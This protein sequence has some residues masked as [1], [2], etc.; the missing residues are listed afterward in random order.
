MA[1]QRCRCFNSSVGILVVRTQSACPGS[2]SSNPVSIPR[3]EFWSFGLSQQ[4]RH[5]NKRVCFN[6]SVGILVVRTLNI[7]SSRHECRSFNSSVG[8]LVVRT[9]E[10]GQQKHCNG[11]FNSSV[12]ILVVRTVGSTEPPAPYQKVSIPRSEFWSFGHALLHGF[13]PGALGVSIPR[14]EFWS[15]GRSPLAYN[16]VQAHGFNSSVGI[17]VVRTRN[18]GLPRWYPCRFNS[19]VGILVVRTR[20]YVQEAGK[21]EVFQF[22]G[23]NSGRSDAL[24]GH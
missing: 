11:G 4:V 23:R 22:L 18:R 1:I 24:D 19:S 13:R 2:G 3:S 12:G 8:I 20:S 21:A 14:S 9:R 5:V 7:S 6:S 16:D 17:L 15:F 10:S